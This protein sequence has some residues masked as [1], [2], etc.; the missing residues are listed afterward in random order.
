VLVVDDSGSMNRMTRARDAA[1]GADLDWMKR[2]LRDDDEVAVVDF[3]A[4]AA[5]RIPV[6]AV[7]DLRPDDAR[8]PAPVLSANR[9]LVQPAL[10]AIARLQPTRCDVDALFLSDGQFTDLPA[11]ADAGRRELLADGIHDLLLLVPSRGRGNPPSQFRTAF[12]G[13]QADHFDGRNSAESAVA[14]AE[15]VARCTGQRL[16]D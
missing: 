15:A 6:T 12:P 10:T 16:A 1:L 14:V 13:T 8:V 3:A 2:N 11:S 5:V 7:R 9:T 4:S